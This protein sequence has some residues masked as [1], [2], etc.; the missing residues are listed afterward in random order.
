MDAQLLF[1][2]MCPL[3]KLLFSSS[4]LFS[5]L[6][7][8]FEALVACAV[9]RLLCCALLFDASV[10]SR[11]VRSLSSLVWFGYGLTPPM[12]LIPHLNNQVLLVLAREFPS[13]DADFQINSAKNAMDL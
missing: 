2:C 5:A 10:S 9:L 12:D 7:A 1:S 11:L 3:S 8:L 6:P 13:C 4:A